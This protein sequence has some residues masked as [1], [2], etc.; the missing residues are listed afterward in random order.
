MIKY[1]TGALGKQLYLPQNLLDSI[2][3]DTQFSTELN[4]KF[5]TF[6]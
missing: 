5:D 1:Q 6:G 2:V 4:T 3:P